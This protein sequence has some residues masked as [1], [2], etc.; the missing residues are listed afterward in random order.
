MKVVYTNQSLESLEDGLRFLLEKQE[1]SLTKVEEIKNQLLDRADSLTIN[2]Y[3]GNI[4][5]YLEGLNKKHRRLVK[6]SFKI[7][8]RVEGQNIYI[9]DFFNTHQ[10]PS[11][12]KG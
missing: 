10:K 9:T 8:Y 1:V 6:G 4:E 11:K 7:I 12:M 3:L 2:P 5:E